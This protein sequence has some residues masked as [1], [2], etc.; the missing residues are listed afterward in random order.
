MEIAK[1]ED[2][3]FYK[4]FLVGYKS[5]VKDSI[6]YKLRDSFQLYNKNYNI[7]IIHSDY[8]GHFLYIEDIFGENLELH[9][10]NFPALQYHFL[11]LRKYEKQVN[12]NIG[13]INQ[14]ETTFPFFEI[15]PSSTNYFYD[16]NFEDNV[17][18]LFEVKDSSLVVLSNISNK[19]KFSDLNQSIKISLSKI[20][21]YTQES[22]FK[23]FIDEGEEIGFNMAE[24]EYR[25]WILNSEFFRKAKHH[26]ELSTMVK[27]I[28]E[29]NSRA[30]KDDSFKYH[31]WELEI[32]LEKLRNKA[33]E[34]NIEP[35]YIEELFFDG[36]N[37]TNDGVLFFYYKNH[38]GYICQWIF[39]NIIFLIAFLVLRIFKIYSGKFLNIW[40]PI[41]IMSLVNGWIFLERMPETM[42][43]TEWIFP[44]IIFLICTATINM[45]FSKSNDKKNITP[46]NR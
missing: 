14:Y 39:F 33:K 8:K 24:I 19:Y 36:K 44:V 9:C 17:G 37:D 21:F 41:T 28:S 32:D 3:K 23:L 13:L 11:E 27:V 40:T 15:P 45:L 2:L 34:Y 35:D 5:F 26:D 38:K 16:A 25:R 29:K 31:R 30:I 20:G 10:T 12:L 22:S 18:R 42:T 4:S 43:M 46:N 1:N 6:H 7:G